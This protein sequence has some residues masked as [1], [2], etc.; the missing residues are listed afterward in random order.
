EPSKSDTLVS[1]NSGS[2][3]VSPPIAPLDHGTQSPQSEPIEKREIETVMV[4]ASMKLDQN[5]LAQSPVVHYRMNGRQLSLGPQ[6]NG[7]DDWD[8]ANRETD[9]MFLDNK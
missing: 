3:F 1:T 5:S 8:V 6:E 4:H 2:K 7:E 9:K